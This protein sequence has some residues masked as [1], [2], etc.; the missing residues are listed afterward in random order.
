MMTKDE[1]AKVGPIAADCSKCRAAGGTPCSNNRGPVKTFHKARLDAHNAQIA[2]APVAPIE[3][4]RGYYV[5]P[6]NSP[7]TAD[8]ERYLRNATFGIVDDTLEPTAIIRELVDLYDH[9]VPADEHGEVSKERDKLIDDAVED[10]K[11]R[12]D[13]EHRVKTLE[14]E[15]AQCRSY[16]DSAVKDAKEQRDKLLDCERRANAHLGSD[17]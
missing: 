13:L 1:L 17:W 3:R 9:M 7:D 16:Y 2:R 5:P 10:D 12:R 8:A 6:S 15:L 14:E 11:K 4:N